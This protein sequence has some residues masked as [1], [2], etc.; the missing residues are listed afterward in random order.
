MINIALTEQEFDTIRVQLSAIRNF[1]D[2]IEEDAIAMAANSIRI[3][4]LD[5]ATTIE[6]ATT[7]PPATRD[8]IDTIGD[9]D[10]SNAVDE[11]FLGWA[12][13]Q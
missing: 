11:D 7:E 8:S 9:I 12:E 4:L 1:A 3:T 13:Y 10:A 2:S 5:A 6:D